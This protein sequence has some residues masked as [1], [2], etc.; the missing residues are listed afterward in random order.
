MITNAFRLLISNVY[1]I[2]ASFKAYEEYLEASNKFE[3]SNI[4]IGGFNVPIA[5]LLKKATGEHNEKELPE[6]TVLIYKSNKV[7]KWLIYWIV[8]TT[9]NLLSSIL[10]LKQVVPFYSLIRLGLS[11]WFISPMLQIKSI[12][13]Y[14]AQE[15]LRYFFNSGCGYCYSNFIR[16]WL[17]GDFAMLSDLSFDSNKL[18]DNVSKV[19]ITL[20]NLIKVSPLTALVQKQFNT[21]GAS[22]NGPA[23]L[24]SSATA[25]SS[26][27]A[28]DYAE[29]FRS[30]G[31]MKLQEYLR[32]TGASGTSVPTTNKE[33]VDDEY[34][35]IDPPVE[36]ETT[37]AQSSQ[38]ETPTAVK[39]KGWL[40]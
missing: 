25:P 34:D 14:D 22:S 4:N 9:F 36:A 37:G 16:P 5:T 39:K 3:N 6:A 7:H 15:D 31:A 32:G 21:K 35:V 23:P 38:V 13:T 30:F 12:E 33:S 24:P 40:W 28:T 11:V 27:S 18:Y 29:S 2:V 26:T 17:N 20:I 1:P 19:L 10:F 8:S